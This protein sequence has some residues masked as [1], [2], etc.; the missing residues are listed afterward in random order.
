[1]KGSRWNLSRG[2]VSLAMSVSRYKRG[3]DLRDT[4]VVSEATT[5]TMRGNRAK[6]TGPELAFRRA[7]WKAG[8]RGYRV[9]VRSLPGTPDSVFAKHKLSIFVHGCFWHGCP[10][11]DSYRTPKTNS[12]FWKA[13]LDEN[14]ARD[15]RVQSK[16]ID[17]G[18]SVLVLWECQIERQLDQ[19]VAQIGTLLGCHIPSI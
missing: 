11:C 7:I 19:T 15:T 6:D 13:K 14:R 4:L 12:A 16:L 10:H 2:E 8:M 17:A 5:R 9:N 18:Y 3:Y 1:M